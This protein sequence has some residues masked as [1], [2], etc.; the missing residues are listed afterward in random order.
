MK[1]SIVAA[2]SILAM[3]GTAASAIDSSANDDLRAQPGG[4]QTLSDQIR[5]AVANVRTGPGRTGADNLEEV[6]FAAIEAVIVESGSDPVSVL[7]ALRTAS[8]EEGCSL[9][10]DGTWTVV[11]CGAL[12][13]MSD[14][15]QTALGGP[16]AGRETGSIAGAAGGTPPATSL[17]SDYS[18]N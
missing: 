13:Q 18:G 6:A 16:A 10:A 15:V 14:L 4:V 2:I 7:G 8:A 9:Q 11:G 12:D 3:A 5:G 1:R 17:G